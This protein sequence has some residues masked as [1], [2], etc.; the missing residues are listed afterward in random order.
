MPF[1]FEV[2]VPKHLY[3]VASGL[4]EGE[5]KVDEARGTR[6][7]RCVQKVPV[8]SYLIAAGRGNL[9]KKPIGPRCV[10]G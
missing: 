4:Q 6:T 1:T 5:P 3:G 9:E 10:C 8:M 7:F 2:T